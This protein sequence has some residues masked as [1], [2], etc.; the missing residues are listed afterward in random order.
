MLTEGRDDQVHD[1]PGKHG[2]ADQKDDPDD[3]DGKLIGEGGEKE[4]DALTAA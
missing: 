1:L 4:Q 2:N 3:L